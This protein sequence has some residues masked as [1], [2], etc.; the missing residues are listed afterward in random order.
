MIFR[1]L[2]FRAAIGAGAAGMLTAAVVF[3]VLATAPPS[4]AQTAQAVAQPWP[5]DDQ[6]DDADKAA[7]A[8]IMK[9]IDVSTLD[10]SQLAVDASTLNDRHAP[11]ARS[12]GLG[13]GR[14]NLNWS[15]NN[16]PN[17]AAVSV[18]QAVSPFLDTRIGADMTVVRQQPRTMSELLADGGAEPQSSGT[19]WAAITAPGA[20]PLWDKTAVEARVDP[21]QEQTRLGTSLSKTVPLTEEYAL[22]LRN[23]YNVTQQGI[24]PLP[25]NAG[26]ATRSYTT[27]QSAK[28]SVFDTGTSVSVSQTMSSTD[29]KWLRRVGAEQ[30]LFDGVSVSGSIAETTEGTT[31]KS[32][33]AGFKRSW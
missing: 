33:N 29:E 20:G 9:D 11:K 7:D 1:P 13:A 19:A 31:S 22:S 15:A 12:A 17:G 4:M 27:D 16:R 30:K 10:W 25:G 14:D 8:D 32:I 21:N 5:V 6:A 23:G 24:V 3:L 2:V 26:R 28:L 18:K